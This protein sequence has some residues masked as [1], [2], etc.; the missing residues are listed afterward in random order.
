M[1]E[2]P[3]LSALERTRYSRHIILPE[4]GLE[5][6]R[7]LKAASVLVV[8][9]GGLG[10]PVSLYLAAAG[11][12]TIGL[13]DFDEV[14]LSNLQRQILHGVD[15]V[16]SKKLDSAKKRLSALN[17]E[18]HVR[19]HGER[20]SAENVSALISQYD[21]VIDG[22]DNFSTRYLI[23]DACVLAK[24]ANVYG[25]IYRFEGQASVFLPYEGPCYRCI[26]PEPPP[27]EAVPN[28]AEGGVLGVL[29]G[30]V[31]TIQ[32]TEAIKLILGLGTG[33]VGRLLLYD[34]LDMRF[35]SLKLPRNSN[36]P[37]C[38]DQPTIKTVQEIVVQCATTNG[39]G[40]KEMRTAEA[41]SRMAEARPV[42]LLDVRNPEEYEL[43]HIGGCVFIP[44]KELEDRINE[45]D[46]KVETITYCKSGVRSKKA[47]DILMNRGFADVKSM[48]GGI[49]AWIREQDPSM[50]EY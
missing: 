38:G 16:G 35:D 23:N 25:S 11:V 39:A 43:C 30:L 42:V 5:G 40:V 44:L 27:P 7:K 9:A 17:P 12:G 34:A 31:G 1:P 3:E 13:V 14:D 15:D 8:G 20:L 49:L 4:V 28:C 21:L 45:L 46:P 47:A 24:K 2:L 26:F 22:T 50:Q 18:V 29:A 6:Q 36:C 41:A 19:P 48:Q 33:L 10:S 37:L 32:A